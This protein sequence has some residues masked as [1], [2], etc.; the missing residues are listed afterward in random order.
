MAQVREVPEEFI[1]ELQGKKY[2]LFDGLLALAHE[3]GVEEMDADILM[4]PSEKNN[5]SWIIKAKVKTSKGTFYGIGDAN[6]E[7]VNRNIGKHIIRMAETRATARALR[8]AVNVGMTAVEELGGD[9]APPAQPARSQ[10]SQGQAQRGGA[11]GSTPRSKD[12]ISKSD[13]NRLRAM[14]DELG[15]DVDAFEEK[16]GKI[17]EM[18]KARGEKWLQS[19]AKRLEE[20]EPE[21][22][23]EEAPES[24][25]ED[26]DLNE[27]DFEDIPF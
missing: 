14:L 4:G 20:Q 6:P 16:S 1:T 23:E 9:D 2:V 19:V 15:A 26:I 5:H 10:G 7:N 27:A 3:D 17:E 25:E 18:S 13:A 11:K 24:G 21:E 22:P 8:K 12:L